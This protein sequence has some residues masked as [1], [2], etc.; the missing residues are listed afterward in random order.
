MDYPYQ[1][2]IFFDELPEVGDLVYEGPRGWFPQVAIRRRFGL[3][4]IDESALLK[5]IEEV[6]RHTAPFN[7]QFLERIK[8]THMP[9]AVIEV[10]TPSDIVKLH[11]QLSEHLVQQIELKHPQREAENYFP[12]M[13]IEWRQKPVMDPDQFINTV[14]QVKQIWVIK[15]TE[16][17]GDSKVIAVFNLR[18]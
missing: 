18:G 11:H 12:H 9:V 10:K 7:I 16:N 6:S 3:R 15:D 8:P 5:Q 2:V 4:S 1:I 17:H 13:T 14:K